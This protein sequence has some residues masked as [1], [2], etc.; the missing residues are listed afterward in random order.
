M[1]K[2]S[3]P[4]SILLFLFCQLWLTLNA[5]TT[6]EINTIIEANTP[7]PKGIVFEIVEQNEEDIRWSISKVNELSQLVKNHYPQVKI[8]VVAHGQELYALS[9]Y[10]EKHYPKVHSLTQQLA[11]QDIRIQICGTTASWRNQ[12]AADFPTYIEVVEQGP[13]QIEF[14]E[15]LGY[16]LIEITRRQNQ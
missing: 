6:N 10:R 13:A 12:T 2:Q 14:Y 16:T 1:S 15:D 4:L 3:I 5:S 9:K 7:P 8:I 11:K